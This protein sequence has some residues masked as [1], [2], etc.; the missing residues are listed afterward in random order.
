MIDKSE[1]YITRVNECCF[2]RYTRGGVPLDIEFKACLQGDPKAVKRIS[3]SSLEQVRI[4][5]CMLDR[6]LGSLPSLFITTVNIESD[7]YVF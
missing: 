6:L 7:I 2:A 4:K 5:L 3:L 1:F